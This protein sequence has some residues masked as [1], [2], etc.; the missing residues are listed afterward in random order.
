MTAAPS[1]NVAEAFDNLDYGT[2]PESDKDARAWLQTHEG[3]LP[4]YIGGAFVKDEAA[5]RFDVVNPYTQEVLIQATQ[6]S[7]QDVGK[8]VNFARNAQKKWAKMPGFAR[9]KCLYAIA[10]LINKHARL[11]AV[12][13]SM[14]NGKPIRESRDAD[15][16]L[17]I[18]HFYHH[19]GWAQIAE[20][21]FPDH[22]PYGVVGQ[23]I[24]WNFPLLMLAWKVAPA[25]ALGNTVVLKPAE[26][27]PLTA[28]LF[29]QI[30]EEAGL[31]AGVVNILTGDGQTGAALVT[32]KDINKVAFTGST[33]VG[34]LI[35]EATAGSGKAL[36]LELGGK[37]PYIVFEDADMDSA[38]EGL[39]DAIWF[40][41]GEVCC[42]GSRLLVQESIAAP[43]IEKL[44]ARMHKLRLGDPLDK[45]IDVGCIVDATQK[46]RITEL[47]DKAVKDG[48]QIDQASVD[49]C[50]D[51]ACIYPPTLLTNI[52]PSDEIA[53]VEIFG[54]VLSAMTFKNQ[55]EALAIANNTRY[56][57]AA[58]VWSENINMALELAPRLKAG[59]VWINGSN[60]F[61]AAAG[62]GGYRESGYGR[63][64]GREGLFA[65]MKPKYEATLKPSKQVAPLDNNQNG[66]DAPENSASDGHIDATPKNYIGGKQTRP[67]SGYSLPVFGH[68]GQMLGHV[69]DGNR[70][71]IR[72]AV[73]AAF[74]A[75]EGWART[76]VH[77]RA[78]ILYYLAENLSQRKDEFTNLNSA[79]SGLSKTKSETEFDMAIA[80]IF[81]YA[82]WCDKYEGHVHTPPA[83]SVVLAMNE[84]LGVMGVVCPEE[85]TLL[86]MISLLLPVIAM[87]NT[88][89]LIPSEHAPLLATR[90]MQVLETSDI[91]AGVV[92]IVTGRH[93]TLVF[94]LAQHDGVDGLWY[95]GD[96]GLSGLV[97]K[98]STGNLKQT[99]VNY[100]KAR[101]WTD[102][103][104]SEGP[105]FLRRATQVK[106][107]W[108][109]YGE[110]F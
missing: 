42:G 65:Y 27:T 103:T 28:I 95:F 110:T 75:A 19:A 57:L 106:N 41:Q 54:P 105:A 22:E 81:A 13:E 36:T 4:L 108:V 52:E 94:P 21:E 92:N 66:Q 69:G 82:G 50:P 84:P 62:F 2:A 10:R 5:E 47:V 100:G 61:D 39:V 59:V 29:A 1:Q 49:N 48:A 7:E 31:P 79:L 3:H 32:H 88:S 80:R 101:D 16:P 73:E 9:A 40:N 45:S 76:N 35:R 78:Q 99:W 107:I 51:T 72:N 91:P 77:N 37:S 67:D 6:A 23:V 53:Q 104:Q 8:A 11:F 20:K 83:Q 55:E 97:E 74:K 87:G 56:G 96:T 58:T 60:Q 15:I 89:V 24:P 109:P 30:C 26:Q 43:F 98:E 68:K 25:L 71:D 93:E 18:R 14:D 63:E 34:R 64:G 46:Q 44:K 38:I 86:S 102:D 70:K 90:L 12:L 85:H 33:E 17:V